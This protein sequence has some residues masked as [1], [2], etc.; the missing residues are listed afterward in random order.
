[1]PNQFLWR[2]LGI[3]LIVGLVC[4]FAAFGFYAA[5]AIGE[6]LDRKTK[7]LCVVALQNFTNSVEKPRRISEQ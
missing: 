1:M 5:H 6:I 7:Q 4:L 2:V 3:A